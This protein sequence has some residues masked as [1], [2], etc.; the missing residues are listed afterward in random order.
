MKSQWKSQWKLMHQEM[1][2]TEASASS[3]EALKE[4]WDHAANTHMQLHTIPCEST[5]A[6]VSYCEPQTNSLQF[7]SPPLSAFHS[8]NK[9]HKKAWKQKNVKC[10]NK[11]RDLKDENSTKTGKFCKSVVLNSFSANI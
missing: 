8:K 1:Q 4:S 9:S 6:P 10:F 7:H 5:Q 11:W 3:G 2:F